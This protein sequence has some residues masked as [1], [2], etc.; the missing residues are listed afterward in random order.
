[1]RR[2]KIYVA[3]PYTPRDADIHDAVRVAHQNTI[4]AIK[5]GIKIIEKG[6]IPFIPHLTHFIHLETENPLPVEF[7]YWYDMAWLEHCDAL[8][9]LGKSKGADK[10]LEWARQHGLRIFFSIDEIPPYKGDGYEGR[11]AAED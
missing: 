5:A 11:G 4:K 7:Y 6:H 1:M 3:G 2:L 9:Y 10:E 8:L